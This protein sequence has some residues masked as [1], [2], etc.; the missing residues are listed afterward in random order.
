MNELLDLFNECVTARGYNQT[1][2]KVDWKIIGT[3]MFFRQSAESEDWVRNILSAIPVF[4]WIDHRWLI[5]PLGAWLG[6]REV[7]RIVKKN[8]V[9][10]FVGYSQGGWYASYGA[11]EI[12]A[13]AITF[14]CPGLVMGDEKTADHFE[15]VTH[16]ETPVDCVAR[17]P[18]WARKGKNIKVLTR[19][20]TRPVGF[21]ETVW[22]TGH[23][24]E[25]YRQRLSI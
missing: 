1:R 4:A 22:M 5:I 13:K 17:L 21:S 25:E 2:G 18:P 20:A 14:G 16:Y 15:M 19:P 24:A 9:D 7:R 23:S 6:W 10:L 3:T 8:T 11:C 12:W